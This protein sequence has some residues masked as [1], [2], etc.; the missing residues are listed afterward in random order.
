M[1]LETEKE[2]NNDL[3]E[4]EITLLSQIRQ[5]NMSPMEYIKSLQGE[6]VEITP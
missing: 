2:D 3:T 6:Q 1:P 5:S 4:E